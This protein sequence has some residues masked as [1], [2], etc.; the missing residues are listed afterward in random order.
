MSSHFFD[1]KK[2]KERRENIAKTDGAFLI[3]F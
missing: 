2:Y 3:Q 1:R